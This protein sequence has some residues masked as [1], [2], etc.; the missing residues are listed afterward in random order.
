MAKATG[1]PRAGHGCSFA[2]AYKMRKAKA[3]RGT[4]GG[5]SINTRRGASRKELSRGWKVVRR[6]STASM[7][8]D[9]WCEGPC[10]RSSSS[11]RAGQRAPGEMG[12]AQAGMCDS[13]RA[14]SM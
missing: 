6:W 11:R 5:Q 3:V 7:S 8:L 14:N 4:H 10:R 9:P 1:V 13:L 12:G 2:Q